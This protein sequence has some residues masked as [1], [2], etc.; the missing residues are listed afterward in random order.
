MFYVLYDTR[1][2]EI[3]TK[4][5]CEEFYGFEFGHI[6]ALTHAEVIDCKEKFGVLMHNV[7]RNIIVVPIDGESDSGTDL[8]FT[9]SVSL[10]CF[11]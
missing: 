8:V 4:Y 5:N 10:H 11:D 3:I 2:D 6:S 9:S 1:Y 7:Y